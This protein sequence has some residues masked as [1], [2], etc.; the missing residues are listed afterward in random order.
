[1]K[2]AFVLAGCITLAFSL[3]AKIHE[4]K[5]TDKIT[6]RTEPKGFED[7]IVV[8]QQLM[9]EP[10]YVFILSTLCHTIIVLLCNTIRYNSIGLMQHI[11]SLLNFSPDIRHLA[12]LFFPLMLIVLQLTLLYV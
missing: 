6:F 9:A 8:S 12:C 3:S 1:M 7:L 4:F 2:K 10:I 11:L 5:P